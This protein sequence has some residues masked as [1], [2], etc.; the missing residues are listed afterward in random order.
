M[1]MVS[2]ALACC[3][4]LASGM[5]VPEPVMAQGEGRGPDGEDLTLLDFTKISVT[6]NE[7]NGRYVI[8]IIASAPKIPV[9]TKID[10][11]LTWRSQ[12]VQTF[13][14]DPASESETP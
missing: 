4:L 7:E 9:G 12:L 5:V 8:T 13:Y 14:R 11:L 3:L 1:L 2:L 6:K 10:L